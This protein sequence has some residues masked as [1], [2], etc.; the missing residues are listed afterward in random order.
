MCPLVAVRV[1]DRQYPASAECT[2]CGTVIHRFVRTTIVDMFIRTC[3]Y[4]FVAQ[5]HGV[6]AATP[7]TPHAAEQVARVMHALATPSRVRIL[8]RLREAPANVGQLTAAVAM[9]QPAVSHQLRILRD[10]GFVVTRRDGRHTVYELFDDHVAVLLDEA[11]R[12]VAHLHQ[13][14]SDPPPIALH[15]P[16]D[17]QHGG[18]A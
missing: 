6:A 9:T 12:H 14:G 7:I 8:G 10:S 5:T 17:H 3:H 1:P 2:G 16:D 4:L 18:S 15:H 13:A 11:L